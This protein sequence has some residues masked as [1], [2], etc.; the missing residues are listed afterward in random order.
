MWSVRTAQCF[1]G[2]SRVPLHSH[3]PV[4]VNPVLLGLSGHR[5]LEFST[6]PLA[7]SIIVFH[8]NLFPFQTFFIKKLLEELELLSRVSQ[9]SARNATD[10]TSDLSQP[11]ISYKHALQWTFALFACEIL[12]AL[13]FSVMYAII[14]RT[15]LRCANALN[16][17]VYEKNFTKE[18]SVPS[19]ASSGKQAPTSVNN[20]I[21]NDV[22][23]VYQMVYMMPLMVGSPTI[24]VVTLVYSYQL[25]GVSSLAGILLFIVIFA[26]QL[27]ITRLQTSLRAKTARQ[28]DN[29]ITMITEVIQYIRTIKFNSWSSA[30]TEEI[31][32]KSI[33]D[34]T[35]RDRWYL[36]RVSQSRKP[37]GSWLPVLAVHQHVHGPAHAHA[38]HGGEHTDAH[39]SVAPRLD[40]G[41]CQL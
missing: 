8:I 2:A 17:L 31:L 40:C 22:W 32:G 18:T 6:F 24:I 33:V 27:F 3:S 19:L 1:A 26:L 37:L 34:G 41:H 4:D 30:F 15:G 7:Q 10:L 35:N 9:T 16:G 13:C 25:I 23:R 20:L 39:G 11:T 12:R 21:S 36:C 5:V 38:H 28:T 14:V 29:R